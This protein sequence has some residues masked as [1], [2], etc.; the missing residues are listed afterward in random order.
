MLLIQIEID[1]TNFLENDGTLESPRHIAG[2][3]RQQDHET[4]RW[5]GQKVLLE[6][7]GEDS[8]IN[9]EKEPQVPT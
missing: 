8:V 9:R 2:Q 5:R 1:I 7:I 6:D 3:R 4:L